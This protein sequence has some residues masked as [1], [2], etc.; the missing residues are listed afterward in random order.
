MY[1][2]AVQVSGRDYTD[3]FFFIYDTASCSLRPVLCLNQLVVIE[4]FF[5][6][7]NFKKRKIIMIMYN[8]SLSSQGKKFGDSELNCD[9]LPVCLGF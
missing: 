5:K 8:F 3:N 4:T 2:L 1:V 9:Q 6:A 7:T